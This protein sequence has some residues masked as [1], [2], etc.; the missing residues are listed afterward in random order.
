MWGNRQYARDIEELCAAGN[1]LLEEGGVAWEGLDELAPG[2]LRRDE[3][4]WDWALNRLHARC[5]ASV[6]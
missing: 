5:P 3:R 4:R 1:I 6:S 2:N